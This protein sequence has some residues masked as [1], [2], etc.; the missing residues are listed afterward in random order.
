MECK[1]GVLNVYITNTVLPWNAHQWHGF[2]NNDDQWQCFKSSNT[3]SFQ[4]LSVFYFS[5]VHFSLC[6]IFTFTPFYELDHKYS[7]EGPS[8]KSAQGSS[9]ACDGT[10]KGSSLVLILRKA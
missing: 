4:S 10:L 6:P 1:K 7:S 9:V 3:F 5:M 8:V 2:H